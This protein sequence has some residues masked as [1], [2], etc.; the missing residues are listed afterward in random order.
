M[1]MGKMGLRVIGLILGGISLGSTLLGSVIENK[2]MEVTIDEKI[3][4]ALE[5]QSEESDEAEE[6]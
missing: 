1:N 2:Q 5:N 4:E 3:K 6:E